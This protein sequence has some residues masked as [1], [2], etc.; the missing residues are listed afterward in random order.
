MPP[1]IYKYLINLVVSL[2][3]TRGPGVQMKDSVWEHNVARV[4]SI[5]EAVRTSWVVP[6]EQQHGQN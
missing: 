2:P 5:P 3:I 1:P 6:N 4:H